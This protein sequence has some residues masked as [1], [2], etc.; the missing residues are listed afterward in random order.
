MRLHAATPW[1]LGLTALSACDCNPVLTDA[2]APRGVLVHG[3]DTTPP[4][5]RLTVGLAT[6]AIGTPVEAEFTLRNEGN[7]PLNVSNIRFTSDAEVCPIPS[8]NF[9]IA[10]PVSSARRFELGAG[11]N[12]TI[13]V[14]FVPASGA[15]ECVVLSVESNDPKNA[16]LNALITGQGNAPRLC[17]DRAV[18]DFGAVEVGMVK[19]DAVVLESCGTRALT[20]Q[21]VT[22]NGFFP[23]FEQDNVVFPLTL[24]PGMTV[25][26][27]AHF[28]PTEAGQWTQTNGRAGQLTFSADTGEV[29]QIDLVGTS[30]LPPSCV[31]TAQPSAINFGTVTDMMAHTAAVVLSNIGERGCTVTDAA[32]AAPGGPFT[33]AF[34]GFAAGGMLMPLQTATVQVTMTPPGTEGVFNGT[35]VVTSDDPV[36][37]TIN[38]PLE[39][40]LPG[41]VPCLL[42]IDPPTVNFGS[43]PVN[44]FRARGVTVRNVGQDV[45]WI[46]GVNLAPGTSPAFINTTTGFGL[47]PAGATR[48]VSVGFRPTAQ[49]TFN[50]RL[51]ITAADQP[52]GGTSFDSF[53]QLVGRTGVSGICVEPRALDFGVVNQPTTLPFTI[54]ACGSTAV[55]V[56][57]LP[58]TALDPEFTLNAPPAL[59]FTLQPG[60]QQVVNVTYT[61]ADAQGDT[62][63]LSVQSDDAV[64]PAVEV[65]LTGGPEIVPATAGR[66]LY[67]WQIPG[68]QG[69]DVMKFPL[70]GN[71]QPTAFWGPRTG[72]GC[73]GCHSISPDGKY[74]AVLEFAKMRFV[75][76]D[77]GLELNLVNSFLDP[78]YFSWRPNINTAPAYQFAYGNGNKIRIASLFDGELRELQGANEGGDA[79]Q[80]MPTWGTNGKIAFVKGTGGAAMSSN[81]N[82]VGLQGPTDILIVDENGGTPVPVVGASGNGMAN[83]YPQYSP[84]ALWIAFTQSASAMSTVAAEDA[85]IRLARAD[86]TGTILQMSALNGTNGASSYPTWAR[87]GTFLSFSSQRMGGEGDWDIYLAPLDPVTGA[88]G[89]AR[90]INELNTSAFEH[91]AQWSP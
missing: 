26:V 82:N 86:N 3:Q 51:K 62:G 88:D 11:G 76:A 25:S 7:A 56:T 13:R 27:P 83:Y 55:T 19:D 91:A 9:V 69:G 58:F 77:S 40:N 52:F 50:G 15:P 38:I 20:L 14:R 29:Y 48:T 43:A 8:G 81:G 72:K 1:I 53:V 44:T 28:R 90:N 24:E 41:E 78:Q 10:E 59:P 42:E 32:V 45:C 79:I 21:G 71:T 84:N 80:T 4:A 57:G 6:G 39:V 23:P 2:P 74:V 49:G 61:P 16:R 87:D 47:V 22:R 33:A 70:Q 46:S 68:V 34:L 36:N 85:Q 73:A 89:A 37:A 64:S 30:R 60:Q 54:S 18:V 75:E 17:T 63:K 12:T 66:Y 31:L 65:L 67:Y 35:L 5:A